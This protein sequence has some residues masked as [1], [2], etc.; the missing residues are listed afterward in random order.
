MPGGICSDAAAAACASFPAVDPG[1]VSTYGDT[2]IPLLG[3]ISEVD[4]NYNYDRDGNVLPLGAPVARRYATDEYEMFAQDSWKLGP[5]LTVT[6][7][8]R[9]SLFSPPWEVNGLQVAPDISLGSWFE[10]R[11]ALMLAGRS[12]SEGPPVLSGG[13]GGGARRAVPP[14]GRSTSEAPDVHF[15][16]AGPANNKPGYYKWDK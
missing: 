14:P 9:Y 10:Q 2:F 8:L 6:A 15:D 13:G 11:R 16:L 7:G 5:N 1:G 4:A 12:T 3:V